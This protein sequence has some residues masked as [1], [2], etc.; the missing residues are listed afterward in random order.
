MRSTRRVLVVLATFILA[1]AMAPPVAVARPADPALEMYTVEGQADTISE[2]APGLEL[3]ALRQT[4]SGVR[5]DVVLTE[6]QRD[7]LAA[8]GVRVTLKRNGQGQTV[9][10][11]AAAQAANGFTVWRSWDEPGGIRDELVAVAN[12]NR[13]LVKLVTLGRTHQ[14]RDIIALKV[15][16]GARGVPD[17]SR[18]A[19]LYSS[20]QHAREWISVEVNRRTL[21]HVINRWK[22]DD[23]E[24]K[25]VLRNTE[26]WF[27]VVANPDGYQYSFDH[28]RL[29]RKNA[30]DNNNDGQITIGDGVDPNRNFDEHW[31]YDNEGSSPNPADETY[32]GPNAASE[33]ETIA[34]QGLIDKVK[35]RF[36]SNL[37]SFGEWLLYP[38]GWQVGTADAD[39]PL[40]VALGGTDANPAIAGFNPGQSADTLYVTNGETT[41]YADTNGGTVA[42]T[43]EL[44]E[45]VP[46]AG[47]VFPDDEA[48]VQAEFVKTLP[49]HLGLAKSAR[50]PADPVSPVGI[51][52][53]P[54]YLDQDDIDP[55]N[56]QT[57]VFDFRFAVSYGDP[58]EVRVLA[59]R[60]L[61]A[62]TLK[63]QVGTG[64][65]QSKPTAEWTGGERYGPGNGT[66]FHVVGG[67]VTGTSPGDS[68]RV[69]FEGG[70]QVSGSFTYQVASNSD[71][72][73]LIVAAEDYTGASP[74]KPGVT[75]PQYLSYYA[76][77]LTANGV[78]F[79]VYD[80]DARGR[81]APDNLGVLSHYDAV[82]WYTGDDVVTREL[83]WGPGNA[84][85]LAMQELLEVRDFLNEGGRVLYT[86]QRAGQQYTTGLGTQLY[87]PFENRQCRAD[88]VVEARC[89]ALSG[90]GNSQGDPIEYFF[91]AAITSPDGGSDP[92][93]G[94]PFPING[95]DD[96]LAGLAMTIN[97]ADSAQNQAS[98][99]SF[100]TTGDFLKVTDPEGSFPQFESWPAAEYL[101]GLAGP[102]D[103]H[104]GTQFMW[105]DRADEAYKRLSR[106]ITV[107]AGGAT[108][109]F[110]T[111]YNLELSFDYLIVEAHTVGQD[112]WTT[113]PDLNGHTSSDLSSDESC[114][115]G[116]SN[117]A[118]AANVLHPFLTHYQTFD[119]ATGTCS[120]TGT[121]GSWNAANGASSGW[122]QWTIDLGAYA[123]QQVELSITALSDWGVQ[124]FPGVFI[125]DIEVSTGEGS[126]SFEDDGDVMDGWTVPGAPQDEAGIEGPNFN[127][128][129]RRGG[130]GIKEGAA[131]GT[132]DTVYLGFGFEGVSDAATR[133]TVM[134]RVVD[135]LLR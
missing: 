23:A 94:E 86:G 39:N 63:Y 43:P 96:P 44:G 12:A 34:M 36:Q 129:V 95:I 33:P 9:S 26:L 32:R 46:G 128:W 73:V 72:R 78:A 117:P 87:D 80:V 50:N 15:T 11:Q 56:G 37:H 118:D 114:P 121:T 120:N 104:T 116:W 40:Y 97:G 4:Q 28:E 65:V 19:V 52:V 88:P 71:R 123:N 22:A 48:L 42:F 93:T 20:L 92:N 113:L 102:F 31:G 13:N 10:Q 81:T 108:L 66:H 90:S 49:F 8:S 41:D 106:T 107:P 14:G 77:A 130:L 2:A 135:Y 64:P 62:V 68:V 7:K 17:G 54:F 45:G 84:S 18:P 85:R 59:K 51:G 91:G 126:T 124:Q 70:G 25:S 89:L 83:G 75:A 35:P 122:Q 38:Q 55:Q 69:W 79:D 109:S 1:L 76:D 82:V 67:Q 60:S 119:P 131:V 101:S 105:S 6:D 133:N 57:S 53:E 115:G 3:A 111:S 61:G 29:W 99:S 132:P 24:I 16:Q 100:I 134:D 98:N 47:F 30:R 27:V 112:N 103:P 21:H 125:D 5:A 110:W 58:Q 127:D 74:P